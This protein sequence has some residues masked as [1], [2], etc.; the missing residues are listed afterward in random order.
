MYVVEGQRQP[1]GGILDVQYCRVP[2]G[3]P[4][5]S[6][7]QGHAAIG[8]TYPKRT[9]PGHPDSVDAI[10]KSRIGV[11]KPDDASKRLGSAR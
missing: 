2:L 3:A 7:A 6:V 9:I 8:E 4:T 5:L 1:D 11:Q 10:F